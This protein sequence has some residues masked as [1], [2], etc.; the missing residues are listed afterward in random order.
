M[1]Y[2]SNIHP[3]AGFNSTGGAFL[4]P[5]EMAIKPWLSTEGQVQRFRDRGLQLDHAEEA[6]LSEFLR[7]QNYYRLSGYSRLFLDPS[8]DP[9]RFCTGVTLASILDV[10]T[11]DTE[12]RRVV[13]EG[14]Q[15]IELALRQRISYV[16]GRSLEPQDSYLH[17]NRYLPAANDQPEQGQ[18][19]ARWQRI[20]TTQ[21]NNRDDVLASMNAVLNRRR[22]LPLDHYRNTGDAVPLWVI[23]E[24]L[25]FGD[26]SKLIGT[27]ADHREAGIV[28]KSFGFDSRRQLEM[29]VGN[30]AFLRNIVAHHGRLWNR[31]LERKVALPHWVIARKREFT[32]PSSPSALILLLAAW[33]DQIEGSTDYS[34]DLL[35]LLY[36]NSAYA[37]G[38]HRPL[39]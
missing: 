24:E 3:V 27:W 18:D 15:I 12:M 31:R 33:V 4:Y 6:T 37:K 36:E 38:M 20:R 2:E 34:D 25:T 11:L 1:Y 9:E 19:V 13:F 32:A 7:K 28:A 30:I 35:D 21:R 29:A 5:M 23:S 14:V 8:S 26:L 10:Y 22:S 39:L 16:F 17:P